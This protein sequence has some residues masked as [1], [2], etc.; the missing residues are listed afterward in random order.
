M[1]KIVNFS[2]ILVF[3]ALCM[4]A[5]NLNAQIRGSKTDEKFANTTV[6]YKETGAI[7]AQVLAQLEATMGMGDVVRITTAPPK[8]Q[9]KA[10]E[11]IKVETTAF[12]QPAPRPVPV[13]MAS[14]VG[15]PVIPTTEPVPAEVES[16]IDTPSVTLDE[17]TPPVITENPVAKT[18]VVAPV[19]TTK[20][21]SVTTTT[22]KNTS[23]KRSTTGKTY[24][25]HHQSK[26]SFKVF[27]FKGFKKRG[28]GKYGCYRF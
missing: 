13:M 18:K 24:K 20:A 7:D 1:T 22:N 5:T 8:P 3:I 23:A 15:V 21:K 28:K 6:V 17:K 9:E 12:D 16:A 25:G 14:T 19:Q 4:T 11:P 27:D 26:R 2:N 10:L